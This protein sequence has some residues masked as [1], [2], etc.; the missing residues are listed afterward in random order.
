MYT[1]VLHS[2]YWY[3]YGRARVL[4]LTFFCRSRAFFGAES[5]QSDATSHCPYSNLKNHEAKKFYC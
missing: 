2:L 1:L 4:I 5:E 3:I